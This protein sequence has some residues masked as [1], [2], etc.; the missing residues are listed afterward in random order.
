MS[1]A[2]YWQLIVH[3]WDQIC[4]TWSHANI[5]WIAFKLQHVVVSSSTSPSTQPLAASSASSSAKRLE[6]QLE[7]PTGCQAVGGL[8]RFPCWDLHVSFRLV[9][10]C[11]VSYVRVKV[12]YLRHPLCHALSSLYPPR[13]TWFNSLPSPHAVPPPG[14]SKSSATASNCAPS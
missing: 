9:A 4:I 6:F 2:Q 13:T 3:R 11:F 1:Y 10:S 8:T 12:N 7:C 14:G 5:A